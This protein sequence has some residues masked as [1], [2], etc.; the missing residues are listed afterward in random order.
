[1]E[2][3]R[4]ASADQVAQVQL[5]PNESAKR[6]VKDEEEMTHTEDMVFSPYVCQSINIGKPHPGTISE[7]ALLSTAPLPPCTYPHEALPNEVI[8]QGKLT[9]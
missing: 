1:M 8:E 5:I 2:M 4:D 6:D 3:A 9:K 7:A